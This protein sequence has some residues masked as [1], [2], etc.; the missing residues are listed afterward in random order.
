MLS[1]IFGE[2]RG[3]GEENII[4]ERAFVELR[5]VDRRVVSDAAALGEERCKHAVN[6]QGISARRMGGARCA[7]RLVQ[8]STPVKPLVVDTWV[9][10]MLH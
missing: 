7:V 5:R 10:N 9:S 1:I 2:T 8:R 4:D 3:K 6:E